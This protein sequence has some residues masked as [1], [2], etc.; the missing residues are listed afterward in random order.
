MLC[1]LWVCA[2][3]YSICEGPEEG[4][5]SH[6]VDVTG[7]HELPDGDPGNQ[8]RVFGKSS[9]AFNHRATSPGLGRGR[10]L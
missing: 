4:A 7:R 9:I 8:I 10:I 1:L 2:Y 5:G 3:K 6:G